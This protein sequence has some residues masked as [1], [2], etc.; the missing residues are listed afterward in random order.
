MLEDRYLTD[1]K[2]QEI[3]IRECLK[4]TSPKSA[5][6]GLAEEASDHTLKWV[7]I[8]INEILENAPFNRRIGEIEMFIEELKEGK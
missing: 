2:I 4:T 5:W 1:E 3:I 7:I 6:R 8:R